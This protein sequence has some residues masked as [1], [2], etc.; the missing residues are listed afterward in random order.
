MKHNVWLNPDR[1]NG[2]VII[3]A[4]AVSYL[5]FL[6]R[7]ADQNTNSRMD[8]IVA[9]VDYGTFQIDRFVQNTVDFAK[10]GNHYYSDKPPGAGFLGIPVYAALK[11]VLQTPELGQIV[12]RLSNNPAFQATLNTNGSGISIDKVRIAIAQVIV[13]YLIATLPTV[14]LGLLLYRF[15]RA[16]RIPPGIALFISLA[17]GLLTPAFAYANEFYSHQL[18]AALLFLV[19]YLAFDR[20]KVDQ[21]GRLLLCGFLLAYAVISE[22]QVVLIATVIFLYLGYQLFRAQSLPKISWAILTG[23]IIM[24]GWM[25]YNTAIFGG[26]LKI[27]YAY[28][29]DWTVQHHTGFMSL[30][31]PHLDALWGM[32]FSLF[33]GLFIL[34]PWL[35]LSI[36]GLIAWWRSH[37]FRAEWMVVT[38][39][40][41]AML[42][43]NSSSIMWWGGFA[44]G[45]R[46]FLPA[47]PFLSIPVG[48]LLDRSAKNWSLIITTGVLSLQ[49]LLN[50]WG[51]T[52]AGQS[53]PPDTITNPFTGYAIP[54][55][56]SGNIARNLGTLIGLNG[57][58][59]LF[60]LGF[61]LFALALSWFTLTQ[62]NSKHQKLFVWKKE[63]PLPL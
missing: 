28:S 50:T 12:T 54:A 3:I 7:W 10:F 44:V 30:T 37:M 47:L 63:S 58:N 57:L 14:L 18:V 19:F 2:L 32:T 61:F 40:V 35:L 8:M 41:L 45:P 17:Y 25:V 42:A 29:A 56:Y 51:M 39:T 15:L 46:Y 31:Y 53:F 6:P 4:L 34:S 62:I 22:Y 59:S 16:L 55:W 27:G 43:F 1:L 60:L 33:R 24:A 38:L 52:L 36:P 23:A 49:S 13:T 48:F 11:I 9:V 5:Y 26:P 20:K 21:V